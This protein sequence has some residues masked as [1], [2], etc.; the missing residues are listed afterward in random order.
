M[1]PEAAKMTISQTPANVTHTPTVLVDVRIP[2][3]RLVL[4][5]VKAALAVIPAAII[6]SFLATLVAI[7]VAAL[8]G[9]GQF[10]VRRWTY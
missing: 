7:S 9:D 1:Q 8:I 5:F 2:F 4:F 3:V 10:V 6:L